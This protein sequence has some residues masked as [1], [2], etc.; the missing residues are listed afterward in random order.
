MLIYLL[1]CPQNFVI[2]GS[3]SKKKSFPVNLKKKLDI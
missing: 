3:G 1:L 2:D